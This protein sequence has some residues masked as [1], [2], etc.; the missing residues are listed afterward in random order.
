DTLGRQLMRGWSRAVLVAVFL[1]VMGA[2]Q[3]QAHANLLH[4]EPAPN[5]VHPEAPSEVVL[6][7]SE[8]LDPQVSRIEILGADG[9]AVTSEAAIVDP[10]DATIMRLALPS[11]P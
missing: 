3:V 8:P 1:V 7:F 6:T 2:T 10:A 5:S 9:Q 11:L 4:A